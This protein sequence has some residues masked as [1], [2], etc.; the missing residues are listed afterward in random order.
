VNEKGTN[1]RYIVT[2]FKA[3]ATASIQTIRERIILT[4]VHIRV[5]K[6]KIKIEFSANHPYR[7]ILE[8]AFAECAR[9]REA[10]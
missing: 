8:K 4:A 5:L 9:W 6:T 1:V 3:L 7:D 2:S 10:A